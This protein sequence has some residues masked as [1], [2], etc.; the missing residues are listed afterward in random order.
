MSAAKKNVTTWQPGQSGNPK[1][2]PPTVKQ[3]IVSFKQKVE[4]LIRS[5][6]PGELL[7]EACL[8]QARLAASGDTEAFKTLAPYFLSKPGAEKDVETGQQIVIRIEN[9]TFK[10]QQDTPVID[11]EIIEVKHD[12]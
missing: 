5:K 7:A 4:H 6:V 8:V 3:G 2:R 12:G 9:A 11:G 10:A 1:G